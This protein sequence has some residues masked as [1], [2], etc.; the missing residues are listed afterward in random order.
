MCFGIERHGCFQGLSWSFQSKRQMFLPFDPQRE[1]SRAGVGCC[2]QYCSWFCQC[3]WRYHRPL[4]SDRIRQM[5][6]G[7]CEVGFDSYLYIAKCRQWLCTH[8]IPA[9]KLTKYSVFSCCFHPHVAT[10]CHY[11]KEKEK[12]REKGIYK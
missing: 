10:I 7:C 3:L 8:F 4:D 1:E 6:A 2:L 5:A 11:R 9:Y 12:K